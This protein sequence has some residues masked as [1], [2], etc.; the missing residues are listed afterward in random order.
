MYSIPISKSDFLWFELREEI[1]VTETIYPDT[2]SKDFIIGS[3]VDVYEEVVLKR[4]NLG[5][6]IEI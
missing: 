4:Y 2:R 5:K 6:I 3:F 1:N